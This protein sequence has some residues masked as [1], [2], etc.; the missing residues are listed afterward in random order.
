MSKPKIRVRENPFEQR[1]TTLPVGDDDP[2]KIVPLIGEITTTWEGTEIAYAYLYATVLKPTGY[3]S[4]AARRAYGAIISAKSR[5]AMI[6]AA[7][8]VFFHQF[9]STTIELEMADFLKIYDSASGRRNDIAHGVIVSGQKPRSGWYLEANF[10]SNKRPMTF[11]SP[12]AYT[13][14]QMK[15]IA[16]QFT[17]LRFDVEAFRDTLKEHFQSSDPKYRA[18]Y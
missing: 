8:E 18:R 2:R 12:Y 4:P 7:A 9:P 5:K 1:P 10:Y 17:A 6:E 11:E 16:S 15:R 14:A 3:T 13:S